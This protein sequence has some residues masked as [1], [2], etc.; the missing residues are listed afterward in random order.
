MSGP[1]GIITNKCPSCGKPQE[2]EG[3][4]RACLELAV[5][6]VRKVDDPQWSDCPQPGQGTDCDCPVIGF[7][8]YHRPDCK[9][10]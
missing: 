2:G 10:F 3:V 5:G 8:K 7:M 4:C 6:N 9:Y 1:V